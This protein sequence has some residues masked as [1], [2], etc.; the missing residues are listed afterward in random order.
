MKSALRVCLFAS[1]AVSACTPAAGLAAPTG[2]PPPT[3]MPPAVTST[4]RATTFADPFAYCAAVGTI[5]RP[6]A[7]Y[8]GTPVP[9]QIITGFKKAAGVEASTEPMDALRKS[10]IWR[11]MDAKVYVCNFGANLP[12]DSKA[13]TDQT[14]TE[15]M[16][17]FCAAN[18]GSDFMPMA[19]TGHA[20]VFSWHCVTDVPTVL[21]QI[22]TVDAAGYLQQIW[23]SIGPNP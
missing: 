5:D 10:T 9:D 17:A 3:A 11:C 19:A 20:T 7:R 8:T 23:Y 4:A 14:P 16:K 22:G 13:D 15:A 12:C 2:G 6:D 21:N 1:M 18:P